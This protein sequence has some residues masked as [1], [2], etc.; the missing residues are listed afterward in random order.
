[1][2]EQELG[3]DIGF[4]TLWMLI[5]G[6]IVVVAMWRICQRIG[7]TLLNCLCQLEAAESGQLMLSEAGSGLA[8][9]VDFRF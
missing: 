6:I 9:E 4:G 2:M 8:Q 5:V 1:M 3:S 7:Y